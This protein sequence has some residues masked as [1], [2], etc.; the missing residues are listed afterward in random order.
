MHSRHTSMAMNL[1]SQ[2]PMAGHQNLTYQ[3]RPTA[4]DARE[5]G[6]MAVVSQRNRKLI[7]RP[8][9][10]GPKASFK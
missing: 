4:P 5:M 6:A 2:G 9:D 7:R 3:D 10:L 1:P 8:I